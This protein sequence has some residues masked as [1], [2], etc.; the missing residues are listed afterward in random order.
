MSYCNTIETPDGGSHENG[1]RNGILKAIKLYG[2]KNQFSKISNIN[3][4]DIFDYSNVII[5]IF[6]NDPSFEGQTKKR[7]I[8]PNLQ[9]EIE[10]KTQ[11]E[12]LLWLNANK[13][14]SKIL[15]DNL[16]DRALQRTDLSKIKEL[17]RKSIKERNRLPGKL[18]DC[19]SKSIKDSE[20]KLSYELFY[21]RNQSFLLDILIFLKTIKLIITM[22]GA[23]PKNND[24]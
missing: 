11:Q 3:H 24:N 9:K 6:I 13:K 14:N 12:F 23:V 19:S 10:T 16:F 4:S 22:N 17:D 18:V 15:L 5:S 2:Q 7:I 8:M 21:I 20:I 1:I